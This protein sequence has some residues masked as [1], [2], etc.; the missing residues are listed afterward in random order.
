M[1][2]LFNF[3]YSWL[4]DADYMVSLIRFTWS[5]IINNIVFILITLSY[6]CKLRRTRRNC[7]SF[8]PSHWICHIFIIR[9]CIGWRSSLEIR[10][11]WYSNCVSVSTSMLLLFLTGSREVTSRVSRMYAM[12]AEQSLIR[13]SPHIL[14]KQ[15]TSL[16][17]LSHQEQQ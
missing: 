1:V 5:F 11:T 12:E 3:W 13:L 10:G 16:I 9:I 15:D 4:C 17:K 7:R 8:V 14:E 6:S 2:S